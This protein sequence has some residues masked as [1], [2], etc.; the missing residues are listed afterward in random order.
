MLLFQKLEKGH[1]PEQT[2]HVLFQLTGALRNLVSEEH[3]YETLI[4][5]GAITQ[6]CQTLEIF[7]SDADIVA[8]ISRTLRYEGQSN[9][10]SIISKNSNASKSFQ[11]KYFYVMSTFICVCFLSNW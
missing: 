1:K 4:S 7:S 8:N 10:N 3:I 2:N 9:I 6:L 11:E 5:C